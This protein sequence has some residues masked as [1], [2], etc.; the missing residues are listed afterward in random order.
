[1]KLR[2]RLFAKYAVL[3]AALVSL[4]LI[5]SG[6]TSIWFSYEEN[7]RQLVALQ[8]E[9]AIGAAARIEQ[10]VKNIEH[11]L[12]W[13]TLSQTGT[14]A[15]RNLQRRFEYL[16]LLRQVPAITE[17]YWLDDAGL[18]QHAAEAQPVAQRAAHGALEA[19]RALAH[20]QA[21]RA[22]AHQDLAERLAGVLL[23]EERAQQLLL[24]D[25]RGRE[26]DVAE[27][28]AQEQDHVFGRR[29]GQARLQGEHAVKLG[30]VDQP[31]LEEQR[32]QLAVVRHLAREHGVEPRARHQ[33]GPGEQLAEAQVSFRFG[34]FRQ[35]GR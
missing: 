5:A 18:E 11:Q 19:E 23:L 21:D 26:Q 13:V 35:A 20:R 1:M 30:L 8:R 12:G 3:I 9:K 34:S 27:A 10:Y 7:Q 15:D 33:P 2:W 29:L 25:R 32:A 22:L 4:T 14:D 28:R 31:E 17:V 24:V 6:V 16:K